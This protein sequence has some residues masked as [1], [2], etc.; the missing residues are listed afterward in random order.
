MKTNKQAKKKENFLRQKSILENLAWE[1]GPLQG[2]SCP[3]SAGETRRWRPLR[4]RGSVQAWGM[5]EKE[6]CNP[7]IVLPTSLVI[8]GASCVLGPFF[9]FSV[10]YSAIFLSCLW[11]HFLP[12]TILLHLLSLPRLYWDINDLQYYR[13]L[14]CT[15]IFGINVYTLIVA[16]VQSLSCVQ[17]LRPHGQEPARLFYP[18]DFPGKNTGV[19]CHFLLQGIFPTQELNPYLLCLLHW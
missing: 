19:G 10:K 14:K 18:W 12:L 9:Y 7:E 6:N 4:L 1:W 17:L 16:L 8:T 2:A 3:P 15:M 11:L 13:S 5:R